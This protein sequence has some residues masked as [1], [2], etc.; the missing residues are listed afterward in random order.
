ML[1]KA[2][3]FP[4]FGTEDRVDV[5]IA[6]DVTAYLFSPEFCVSPRLRLVFRTRVPEAPIDEDDE[7]CRTER[8]IWLSWK[9]LM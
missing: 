6:R 8:E 3:H 9:L 7:T 5:S 4:S 1:P 2:E